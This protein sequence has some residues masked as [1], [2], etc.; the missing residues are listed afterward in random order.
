[1]SHRVPCLYHSTHGSRR[2]APSPALEVSNTMV[3]RPI[4][5]HLTQS[6]LRLND[7][8]GRLNSTWTVGIL[9]LFSI[10]TGCLHTAYDPITCWTPSEFQPQM[11]KYADKICWE[12]ST[13]YVRIEDVNNNNEPLASNH[14]P[15]TKPPYRWIPLILLVQAL[16]FKLPDIVLS[17]GQ[18][19]VGFRFTKILGLTDGYETLNMADRAQ[20]GRQVGR[21]VKSWIDSTVLKGCPWGWLTLLFLFTKLLYFINVITQLSI[22][23][24]VLKAENQTSF[25]QQLAEDISSNETLTWRTI[26]PKLPKIVLCDFS[27][28]RLS[29]THS[30]TVQCSFN[31]VTYYEIMFGFL[32]MWMAIVCVITVL[33][34]VGQILIVLVP[35]FRRR[36]V[37]SYLYLSGEVAPSPSDNDIARF[38]GSEI[39]EDGVCILKAIGE[40]SSEHLVRDVVL[41]LWSTTHAQQIEGTRNQCVYPP[42]GNYGS[43][44]ETHQLQEF[45]HQPTRVGVYHHVND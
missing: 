27:I 44:P 24:V 21:Y 43:T 41:Y 9:V 10:L 25:G 20:M 42:N 32:W 14:S 4:L 28:T 1:M 19:L 35:I 36:F 5:R 8:C 18:G 16:L 37:K 13:Y 34:G 17:V 12:S 7:Q 30:Y 2:Q 45:P 11:V 23:N 26:D 15:M 39:T 38:A 22:M 33:S 3:L 40:A 6:S 29:F 31:N